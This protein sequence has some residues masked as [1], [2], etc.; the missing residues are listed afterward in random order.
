VLASDG[1]RQE[2]GLFRRKRAAVAPIGYLET[3]VLLCGD[4]L[5]LLSGF[6][7][8]CVDLIY[9]DPPF[10]SNRKYEVIWGDEAEVRSFEDRWEGGINH[11]ID[12]MRHRMIQ[13]RRVLKETGSVYVHCD[14]SASH[15]LKV[16]LDGIF[17]AESFRNEIVWK[18]TPF[19]G[20]SKARAR[21]LPRSHDLLFFYT[22]GDA[23]TWNAPTSPYSAA[24]LARFKWDDQDGRGPYRKTLLKTYSEET[25]ERL[26]AED[27]L[28]APVRKGAMWSYKQYL[29][30]SSGTV[31]VDDVWVD[32]NAINPVAR[33]RLGY[34]T[35]KPEALLERIIEAS[36]ARGDII[37]DPFCG[38]GTTV[39]VA[40]RLRRQWI[41]MDISPTAVRLMQR[42]MARVGVSATTYGLPETEADLRAL[43]P[44]E[45]QNWVISELHGTHSPRRSGDMGIDG[46]SFLERL[47]IQVKQSDRIGRNVVDNFETA[48]R[49]DGSHKGYIIAFSFGR[50]AHEEVARV[51]AEGLEIALVTVSTL[52]KNPV[53]SELEPGLDEMTE[54]LLRHAKEAA[55]RASLRETP[56]DRRAEELVS[57]GSRQVPTEVG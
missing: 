54:L 4:N 11:Y 38:C 30:E 40:E 43:K 9:L 13:L 19:A 37:L 39:A 7:S 6:P 15:Y 50:G 42:R 49:R 45:F 31:Q 57:S 23:W 18:R 24:Y 21:Q 46:Y 52:L 29:A 32:V 48:I 1:I 53:E 27:R 8:D 47:P 35:Q 34:P 20:S 12:W 55:A 28:V 26:K 10:F 56:P 22:K 25:F 16:M 2:T 44:F 41:G 5:D 3:D 51:K 17:G 33:E 14:P 36:S